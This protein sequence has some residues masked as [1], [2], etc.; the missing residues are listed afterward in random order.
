MAPAA[1][2]V[3]LKLPVLAAG[4]PIATITDF[5]PMVNI[6][7]FG[8]CTTLSN[9]TVASATAAAMGVLTPMPCVPSIVA[10]WIATKPTC[11]L[12]GIPVVSSSDKCMCMWGGV[13]NITSPGQF[14][15]I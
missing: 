8:M 15:V 9:P 4:L 7:T 2:T 1:L 12:A 13:I 10:P 5:V 14:L 6:A 11:L 3:L